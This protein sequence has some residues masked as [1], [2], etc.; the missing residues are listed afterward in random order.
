MEQKAF[1]K[2]VRE[3]ARERVGRKWWQFWR[4]IW[5]KR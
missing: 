1:K 2:G 3:R 5:P 4:L